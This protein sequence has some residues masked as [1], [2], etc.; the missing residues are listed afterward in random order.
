MYARRTLTNLAL[1]LTLGLFLVSC[2]QDNVHMPEIEN[3]TEQ[4]ETATAE[5]RGQ[6]STTV[7]LVQE[8]LQGPVLKEMMVRLKNFNILHSGYVTLCTEEFAVNDDF[9]TQ[10]LGKLIVIGAMDI[11]KVEYAAYPS[12]GGY[13]KCEAFDIQAGEY[14]TRGSLHGEVS[15]EGKLSFTITYRPGTMPF[16]IVSEFKSTEN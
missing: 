2:T 4:W 8:N 11:P 5:F 6:L 9:V 13:L 12:G 10:L 16:D 1:A 15:K 7:P 3:G 14:R